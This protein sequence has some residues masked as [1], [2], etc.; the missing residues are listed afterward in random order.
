VVQL[1]RA[2]IGEEQLIVFGFFF[3]VS[4]FSFRKPGGKC[5]RRSPLFF[6]NFPKCIRSSGSIVE[7]V[8]YT[9]QAFPKE[10]PIP[11]RYC[12]NGL[13]E[14]LG[15][16]PNVS[17]HRFGHFRQISLEAACFRL[18]RLKIEDTREKCKNH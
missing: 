7:K 12:S 14:L 11:F 10:S 9:L 6:G 17:L 16:F 1:E 18:F 13:Q 4:N 8:S 15:A 2:K 5:A 3:Y